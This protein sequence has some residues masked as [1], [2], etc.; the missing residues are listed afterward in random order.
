VD[1][2]DTGLGI[3]E[4]DQK[5]IFDKF[6]R[7]KDPRIGHIP[8]TG[9]GLTLAREVMRLHGG[10]I[11]VQSQIDKGSTFTLTMPVSVEAV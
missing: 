11:T 2:V 1:V 8:G 4:Q 9:L 10:D 5:Q 3:G 7:A 6:Y